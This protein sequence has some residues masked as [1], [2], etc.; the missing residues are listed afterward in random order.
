MSPEEIIRMRDAWRC[1]QRLPHSTDLRAGHSERESLANSM[2]A[3]PSDAEGDGSAD[4]E[5]RDEVTEGCG[6]A[7]ALVSAQRLN[8]RIDCRRAPCGTNEHRQIT[9]AVRPLPPTLTDANGLT[10]ARSLS[11]LGKARSEHDPDGDAETANRAPCA[12][13]R[14]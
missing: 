8:Q 13:R 6:Q 4:A 12:T 10:P 14:G 7:V 5:R 9:I 11:Q 2:R 1:E 3:L